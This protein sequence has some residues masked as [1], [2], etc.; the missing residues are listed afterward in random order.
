MESGLHSY[1]KPTLHLTN[2]QLYHTT[3]SPY[4]NIYHLFISHHYIIPVYI[5]MSLVV[6]FMLL[7]MKVYM[8]ETFNQLKL[9]CYVK[10]NNSTIKNSR[11]N[12]GL[13]FEKLQECAE[14]KSNSRFIHTTYEQTNCTNDYVDICCVVASCTVTYMECFHWVTYQLQW[15]YSL[16]WQHFLCCWHLYSP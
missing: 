7:L 2:L 12:V 4:F 9:W 14:K 6:C 10:L 5:F 11:Q 1:S 13:E 8:T 16:Y 3:N 15:W